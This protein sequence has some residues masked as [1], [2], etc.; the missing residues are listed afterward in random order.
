MKN[1]IITNENAGQRLDVFLTKELPDLTRSKIQKLIKTENILIN[2]KQVT[3]HYKLKKDDKIKIL[4]LE[5][6]KV[7]IKD[8]S[9]EVKK[10]SFKDIE[11]VDKNKDYLVINKPP[12]LIVHGGEHIEETTLSDILEK[13]FPK[14]KKIGDDPM[15][16]GIVH[17]LDKEASG[18]MVVARSQD[19][20]D[21]LKSQFKNRKVK[22]KYTALTFGQVQKES[23]EINFPI[24]RSKKG[25]KMAAKALTVKGEKNTSGRVANTKFDIV[26]RYINFTLLKVKIKTGRTHQIRVHMSAYGHSLVGDHLYGNRTA[27]DKNMKLK[28]VRIFLVADEL[29][30]SDLKGEKKNYK[31]DLP[32]ELKELLK[33]IK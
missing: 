15:R 33:K 32:K 10:I 29:E 18:L 11:I 2:K 5:I 12:G 14:I 4:R 26:K 31:I 24:E 13:K 21:H 28:M 23:D 19:F 3:P 7:K 16:P 25:F 8:D 30:F 1:I 17:R 6:K 20:F 9:K 27:K 22:K